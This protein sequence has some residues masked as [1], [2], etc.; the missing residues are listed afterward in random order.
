MYEVPKDCMS[1][2]YSGVDDDDELYCALHQK[3]VKDNDVCEDYN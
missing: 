2:S 3:M 1:C